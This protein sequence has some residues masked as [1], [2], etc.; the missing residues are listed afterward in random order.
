M[1]PITAPLHLHASEPDV[2]VPEAPAEAVEVEVEAEVDV[3]LRR[4]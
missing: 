2:V 3:A 4:R 1:L